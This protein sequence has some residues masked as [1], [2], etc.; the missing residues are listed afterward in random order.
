MIL[1]RL[2]NAH[3]HNATVIVRESEWSSTLCRLGRSRR[4]LEYW[5]PR[6][7]LSSSGAD[8]L[9]GMRAEN[10]ADCHSTR[11]PSSVSTLNAF[12]AS[13]LNSSCPINCDSVHTAARDTRPFAPTV[14]A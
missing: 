1:P 4:A 11:T 8:P 3:L 12:A 14:N 13:A 7:S 9:A 6:W 5:M 10:Y 2:L